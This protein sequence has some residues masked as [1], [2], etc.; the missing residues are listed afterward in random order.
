M[1]IKVVIYDSAKAKIFESEVPEH[2]PFVMKIFEIMTNGE[3]VLTDILTGNM[4]FIIS[5]LNRAVSRKDIKV[6]LTSIEYR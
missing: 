2:C 1:K 4:H 3:E 6:F 5:E